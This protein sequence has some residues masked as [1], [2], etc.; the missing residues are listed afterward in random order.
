MANRS[1]QARDQIMPNSAYTRSANTTRANESM[2][3]MAKR[4]KSPRSGSFGSLMRE[5][6]AMAGLGSRGGIPATR[7]SSSPSRSSADS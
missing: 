3:Q 2:T 5:V 6:T 4:P 1:G 7:L